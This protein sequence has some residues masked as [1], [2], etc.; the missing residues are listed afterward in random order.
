MTFKKNGLVIKQEG[1]KVFRI[2][3]G[4]DID[5]RLR[6]KEMRDQKHFSDEI[7]KRNANG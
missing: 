7:K 1:K 3:S 2:F 5:R 6:I 4:D